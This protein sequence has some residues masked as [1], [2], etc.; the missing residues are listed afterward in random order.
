MQ[1][2]PYQ[3]FYDMNL[4][5]SHKNLF[6]LNMLFDSNTLLTSTQFWSRF[7]AS[8]QEIIAQSVQETVQWN[9]DCFY[10]LTAATKKSIAQEGVSINTPTAKELSAWQKAAQ[11]FLLTSSYRQIYLD[12][13]QKSI[14]CGGYRNESSDV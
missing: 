4:Y 2:N 5:Q 1:E 9:S 8:Q 10:S 3:N 12:F 14:A 13:V 7:S 6:E 11:E